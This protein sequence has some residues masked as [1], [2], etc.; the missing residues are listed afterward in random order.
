[1]ENSAL[2]ASFCWA[3]SDLS[4]R[5]SSVELQ[6]AEVPL[7]YLFDFHV[8]LLITPLHDAES[9]L[10]K[11][12]VARLARNIPP[13]WKPKVHCHI[14]KTPLW[15]GHPNN[16]WWEVQILKLLIVQ[17]CPSSSYFLRL[18][19][20]FI[21]DTNTGQ[22]KKKVTLTCWKEETSEPTITRYS[23]QQ[24]LGK[25]SK[26]V[27]NWR[28][29]QNAFCC[30]VAILQHGLPWRR[31]ETLSRVTYKQTLRVFLTIVVYHVIVGSL[32]TSL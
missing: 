17:F 20:S 28:G 3:L 26:F 10:R 24:L 29:I 1:M 2:L 11:L 25:L 9:F 8:Y 21:A 15:L 22:F 7:A 27:C 6:D 14:H 31:P 12:T 5:I 32:V 13:L 30:G 4:D 19:R 16:I 23:L 18:M